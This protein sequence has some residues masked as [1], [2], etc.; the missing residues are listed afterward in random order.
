M[1][2]KS[3][4]Q[5]ISRLWPM[6]ENVTGHAAEFYTRAGRELVKVGVLTDLDKESYCSMC[7]AYKLMMD[8]LAEIAKDG[9]NVEGSRDAIKKNP[10]FTTY[11]SASDVF[12]R[13]L[14][15]F[16]LSP[17]ARNNFEMSFNGFD[18]FDDFITKKKGGNP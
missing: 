11:K 6:P 9:V 16:G 14:K 5:G 17:G 1:K 2:N 15:E 3:T 10:A 13:F 18:S 7:L 8:A 4:V 12:L